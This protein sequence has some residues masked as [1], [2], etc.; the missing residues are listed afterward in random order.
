MSMTVT[1]AQLFAAVCL[2]ENP[3]GIRGV[4][5]DGVSYGVAGVTQGALDDVNAFLKQP[6]YYTLGSMDDLKEAARVFELYT[7]I[8]CLRK[9]LP[10]TPENRLR[11]WHPV[12]GTEEYVERVLNMVKE[13]VALW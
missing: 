6:G 9:H 1:I 13:E 4:H 12:G 11:A 3:K 10:L 8:V 5:S 7:Q 2:L